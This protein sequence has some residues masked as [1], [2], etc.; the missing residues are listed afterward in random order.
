MNGVTASMPCIISDRH[1]AILTWYLPKIL[2]DSKKVCLFALTDHSRNFDTSQNAML[3]AQEKLGLL[4]RAPQGSTNWHDDEKYFHSGGE[5]PLGL[6]TLSPAWFSQ[7]HDVSASSG[8]F[9]FTAAHPEPANVAGI[10]KAFC[11]FHQT[12]CIGLAR[13]YFRIQCNSECNPG[14][15]EPSAV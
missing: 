14:G 8:R 5:G 1:G 6:V 10:P 7:G 4:L 11:K 9:I 2:S 13:C 15:N 12:C 3:A